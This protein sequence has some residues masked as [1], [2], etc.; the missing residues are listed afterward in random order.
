MLA[1]A[2]IPVFVEEKSENQFYYLPFGNNFSGKNK[3]DLKRK[4]WS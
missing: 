1:I 3:K 2:I 4:K